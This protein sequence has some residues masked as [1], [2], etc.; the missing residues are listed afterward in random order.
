MARLNAGRFPTLADLNTL[1]KEQAAPIRVRSGL[2]L[3]F[4]P[5]SCGHLPFGAQ[6][7]PRCYLQGEVQTRSDNWHDLFNALVWFTFPQ[8]KAAINERHYRAQTGLREKSSSQRGAV[9]DMATLFDESGMVVPYAD[10]ALAQLLRDFRWKDLFWSRRKEL[11]GGMEFHLFGHGLH[12]KALNP[13]VGLTGQGLLLPV[14]QEFFAWPLEQRLA[15][16]DGLLA[17]YLGD[18]VCCTDTHELTPVP[19]LGVPG[20]WA[21]NEDAAFYDNTTYFRSGRQRRA[22]R[23]PLITAPSSVA[24]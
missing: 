8:A 10:G 7:E 18:P 19:L 1:M 2:P 5:Q 16:L 23:T 9:R 4:V 15:H 14:S 20:W 21:A 22:Q 6:Y 12:E 24:G 11:A 17:D 13:Y 3:R